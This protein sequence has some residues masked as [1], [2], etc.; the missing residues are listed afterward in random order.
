[1][2]ILFVIA[3]LG[4]MVVGPLVYVWYNKLKRDQAVETPDTPVAPIVPIVTP[5]DETTVTHPPVEPEVTV[6]S[7][8]SEPVVVPSE[9]V[10]APAPAPVPEVPKVNNPVAAGA[11]VHAI[12]VENDDGTYVWYMTVTEM[13]GKVPLYKSTDFVTWTPCKNLFE[14]DSRGLY[15]IGNLWYKLLWAPQISQIKPSGKY[16]LTI[17]AARYT[18]EQQALSDTHLEGTGVFYMTSDHPEYGTWSDLSLFNK[19]LGCTKQTAYSFDT[20]QLNCG[21]GYCHLVMRLDSNIFQDPKD[22]RIWLS[23]AWYS[24]T[25]AQSEFECKYYFGEHIAFTELNPDLTVK[26]PADGSPAAYIPVNCKVATDAIQGPENGTLGQDL[27][28]YYQKINSVV[29]LGFPEPPASNI[30]FRRGKM[31][32]I[33]RTSTVGGCQG[34][35]GIVE[36]PSM[37]RR[38][39]WVYM[40]FSGSA[41]DSPNYG[42]AYIAAKS[43]PELADKYNRIAGQ[44]VIPY[45]TSTGVR[46]NFG[47]GHPVQ[48]AQGNWW[49]AYHH[50]NQTACRTSGNCSRDVYLSP[51]EFINI[52]DGRGDVYIKPIQPTVPM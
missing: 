34:E 23:Y 38:G 41:F 15:K 6:V 45:T 43:V 36:A 28:N 42:V 27:I 25:P 13:A 14:G 51:I 52:G 47:H 21:G 26:C 11:D 22:N 24:N 3:I 31:N 17:T 5:K 32:E 49:F 1:M 44:F 46:H 12:R 16:V 50:M 18:D 19:E 33:F 29:P 48:D 4:A 35:W 7:P 20:A 37:L 2:S 10:P 9:P 8:P 39:D 30:D 40:F